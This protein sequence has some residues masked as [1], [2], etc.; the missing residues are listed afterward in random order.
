MFSSLKKY[1]GVVEVQ[2]TPTSIV[3]AGIPVKNI[4]RDISKVW[5]TS[6]ATTNMFTN[7]GT[8]DFAFPKFFLPDFFYTLELIGKYKQRSTSAGVLMKMSRGIMENTW[9]KR[10]QVDQPDVINFGKANSLPWKP[11]LHQMDFLHMYNDAVPKMGLHGLILAAKAGSGKTFA[12]LL[13]QQCLGAGVVFLIV[14]KNSV[15]RVW[16]DTIKKLYGDDASY[17]LSTSGMPPTFGKRFYVFHYETL[18]QAAAFVRQNLKA[19][20]AA[21]PFIGTDECHNFNEIESQRTQHLVTLHH[22]L[23][24]IDP[25]TGQPAPLS[26]WGSGTPWKAQGREVIPFLRANDPLFNAD[27]EARFVKIFGKSSTRALEILAH[28]L[29]QMQFK[30]PDH[31]VT[32]DTPPIVNEVKVKIPNSERYTIPVIQEDMRT[33]I[34][35][36]TRY[37]LDKQ[38]GIIRRYNELLANHKATLTRKSDLDA[39]DRYQSYIKTIRAGYDPSLHK[40]EVKYCN[41][42]EK[43]RIL[44]SLSPPERKEFAYVKSRYK[45][46]TLVI[47]GEA[48][49]N[50]LGK[51]RQEC[52]VEMVRN[53]D[54]APYITDAEKKVVI[55][56]DYVLPIEEAERRL[57]KQGF[58]PLMVY[59]ET[60]KDLPGIVDRFFKIPDANPLLA[61]IKSL[62]TAV[63]LIVANTVIFIN[64]PFRSN[65]KEQAIA[66]VARLGQD[67]QTYVFDFILDTGTVGNLSTRSQDI[68]EWSAGQVAIMLGET[69]T[70]EQR[71]LMVSAIMG[72]PI[73]GI[74]FVKLLDRV[75]A[76][77]E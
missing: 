11:L 28:R 77:L 55:F 27:A 14:P 25:T 8:S 67:T 66:R 19:F 26:T 62:S 56:S 15:T 10:T 64:Q 71:D 22:L 44:P 60:S 9:L 18:D 51:R 30:V 72:Q 23:R 61:T 24:Q 74:S 49:G 46:I 16:E 13:L 29:G 20:I 40:V 57:I 37:Y 69:V 41:D 50:I 31:V 47:M 12:T 34:G 68:M 39:F 45:Y 73:G 4:F 38:G 2:E 42:Y 36:R 75:K 17:W 70:S 48:L 5:G 76:W 3:I 21:R 33:Y 1:M 6:V 63:P 59:G 7:I 32:G 52:Y 43:D 35:E 65:D 58:K 53:V 54:M